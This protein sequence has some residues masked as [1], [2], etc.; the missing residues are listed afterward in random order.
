MCGGRLP[1]L[2]HVSGA[3]SLRGTGP[4]GKQEVCLMLKRTG[5]VVA[6]A[7]EEHGGRHQEQDRE[8]GGEPDDRTEHDAVGEPLPDASADHSNPISR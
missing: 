2:S 3:I 1:S 6:G 5:A 8:G 4:K 7:H